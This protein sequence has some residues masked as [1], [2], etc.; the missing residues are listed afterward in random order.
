MEMARMFTTKK[1]ITDISI[2]GI[3]GICPVMIAWS[4]N[5]MLLRR[6]MKFEKQNVSRRF[7][8]VLVK[9]IIGLLRMVSPS[10][11]PLLR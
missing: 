8:L 11:P 1:S 9:T 4:M 2:Y 5:W 7:S 10:R 6:F 3:F